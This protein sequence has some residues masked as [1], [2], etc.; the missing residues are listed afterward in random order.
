MAYKQI[1]PQVVSEGGTGAQTLTG[2]LTGNG[3][4]AIT[5]N[6][7][8]QYATLVGG[9][10]NAVS[11][12]ASVGTS[13][14][15]LVSNGAGAN[16]SYNDPGVSGASLKLIEYFVETSVSDKQFTTITQLFNYKLII[17]NCLPATSTAYLILETSQDGGSSWETTNYLAGVNYFAYNSTTYTNSNSTTAPPLTGPQN[18]STNYNMLLDMD[19]LFNPAAQCRWNG[20]VMYNDTT[21]GTMARGD[22]LGQNNSNV[23]RNAFRLRYSSGNIAYI[24]GSLYQCLQA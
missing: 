21:L 11:E 4:S 15:I 20:R 14:Q 8:T 1:S 22:F 16:P 9:A 10:S 18:S 2:V 13:G 7:I 5:A 12:V 23:T 24:Y 3:T 17:F 6:A 19:I